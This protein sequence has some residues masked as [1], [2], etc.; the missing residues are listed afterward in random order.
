ML[1]QFESVQVPVPPM[2]EAAMG[3]E[4]EGNFVAFFWG[5]GDELYYSDG[6]ITAC[7]EWDCFLAYIH[8]PTV[9]LALMPYDFGSCE[10]DAKH[11][12]LL[13]RHERK[14][15]VKR[16]QSPCFCP[17]TDRWPRLCWMKRPCTV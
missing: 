4:G 6:F 3:Y 12:L 8:H 2:F 15:L 1:D 11:Y 7:G 13:D 17:N 16:E 10:S 14:M 5:G 9:A